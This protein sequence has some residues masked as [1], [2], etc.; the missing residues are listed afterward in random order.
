MKKKAIIISIKSTKLSKKEKKLIINEKPWGIIL[1]KRNL[2]NFSQTKD[3]IKEI[4]KASNDKNFPIM[5]DEEGGMV[6]RLS[7]FL[8]NKVYSQLFFG[9]IYE[10]NNKLGTSLYQNYIFSLSSVLKTLG[11]NINTVPVLDVIQK[12]THKIIGSRSYSKNIKTIKELGSKCISAYQ[13]S[14]I[15]TVIKHIPGHGAS[16]VDSHKSLPII[17]KTLKEL[18]ELDFQC[19]NNVNSNFAMTAHIIYSK[20]DS[21]NVAT[22]SNVIINEIIRKK[23][24]YKGIIIS[25]DISMKALKFDLIT[26]AKKSL[27]AGCNLVL[28]CAGKYEDSLKLIKQIPYIDAFTRKKTS[29]FYNF[30]S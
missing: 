25:D 26:N 24:N 3:L 23:L 21:K 18:N 2:E 30:L 14:K 16:A 5:I 11:I 1:F 19:F 17:G 28:Y 10:T 6:T 15:G 8:D 22:H 9:N 12:K 20:L 4:K 29:E 7:N 27:E 13:K